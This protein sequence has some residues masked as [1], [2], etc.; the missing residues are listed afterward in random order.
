MGKKKK[1]KGTAVKEAAAQ[2]IVYTDGGCASFRAVPAD[3]ALSSWTMPPTR[4]QS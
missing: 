2:Y 4:S 1:A 3:M